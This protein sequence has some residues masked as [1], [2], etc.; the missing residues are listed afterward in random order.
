MTK[1][2]NNRGIS[3]LGIESLSLSSLL[4]AD[5]MMTGCPKA[6][7]IHRILPIM[8]QYKSYKQDP[9]KIFQM[10]SRQGTPYPY[11]EME[12]AF[13]SSSSSSS[14]DSTFV[15]FKPY[16]FDKFCKYG[17]KCVKCSLLIGGIFN[18]ECGKG[19]IHTDYYKTDTSKISVGA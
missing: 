11:H 14:D 12:R 7:Q 4:K 15:Q 5:M 17:K 10:D 1:T 19:T 16:N 18:S 13:S 9:D 6:V 8:M 3:T 2:F